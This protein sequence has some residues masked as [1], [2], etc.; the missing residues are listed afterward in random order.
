MRVVR[1]APRSKP[2]RH[3]PL[4]VDGDRTGGEHTGK[5]EDQAA[6][7]GDISPVRHPVI[8]P[9]LRVLPATLPRPPDR[10]PLSHLTGRPSSPSPGLLAEWCAPGI[11]LG[12]TAETCPP[13]YRAWRARRLARP[14]LRSGEE[15]LAS[16]SAVTDFGRALAPVRPVQ[17]RHSALRYTARVDRVAS[18]IWHPTSD[19]RSG[20]AVGKRRRVRCHRRVSDHCRCPAERGRAL[21]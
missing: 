16:R 3:A 13:A 4:T 14:S 19:I 2:F 18:E 9:S 5:V 10:H 11:V 6:P 15:S 7:V 20:P 21:E 1:Q 17:G 8:V 12:R